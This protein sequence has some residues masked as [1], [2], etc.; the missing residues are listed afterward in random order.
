MDNKERIIAELKN[1]KDLEWELGPIYDIIESAED[2]GDDFYSN[3]LR[4]YIDKNYIASDD[5]MK[6]FWIN[7]LGGGSDIEDVD[8]DITLMQNVLG[9][10]DYQSPISINSYNH[11]INTNT[12]TIISEA[13]NMIE[14]AK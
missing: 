8:F 9:K 13:I 14:N 12:D 11:L 6:Y 1:L 5:S 3:V 2:K 10:V 4:E 7:A